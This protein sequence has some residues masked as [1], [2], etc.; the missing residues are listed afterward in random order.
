MVHTSSLPLA[1]SMGEPQGV[2]PDLIVSLHARRQ[3]LG[4]APFLVFGDP[5]L[6]AARAERL[7]IGTRI[8]ECDAMGASDAFQSAL[9]I[10]PVGPAI[11]D[12]P[13]EPDSSDGKS[14]IGAIEAGARAVQAGECRALITA[15]L[16]KAVL[17]AAGF[18]HPG[19][20][21]F[22]AALAAVDGR[23]PRPVMMLA[24]E[25]YRT[26]PVTIHVPLRAVPQMLT[27][28]LIIETVKIVNR[29]L[30]R[31]FGI[32]APKIAVAGLNPHAGE[33]GTIGTE[34]R[35]VTG[36]AVAA[37]RASGID[38]IG[39]LPADT[40]FYPTHWS[41]YDCV[42]AMY[43]D[44]ALIPIKTLAFDQGV[45]VTLGLPFV[46]T[47]PDHGTAFTLAG[48]GKASDRSMLAALRLA[49]EMS[50]PKE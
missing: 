35:D 2:G 11:A 23:T 21:E 6:F 4:L 47:S 42:V 29:D 40:L 14:V 7:G 49:D 15:P 48:T 32:A 5:S 33:D 38:A 26:V 25:R 16:H 41:E 28:D 45:N 37:L 9:P 46:R 17:Y 8:V 39:P 3:A 18:A 1:V 27:S 19:H 24:H 13:G 10:M 50:R 30:R 44:Q 20:T 34:D 43:H 22:L 12:H 31:R 36:P